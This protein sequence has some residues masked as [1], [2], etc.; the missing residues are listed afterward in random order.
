MV[1]PTL[2]DTPFNKALQSMHKYSPDQA[3]DESGKWTDS[4]AVRAV[5]G[6]LAGGAALAGLAAAGHPLGRAVL[7]GVRRAV[8]ARR[9]R[10]AQQ[11]VRAGVGNFGWLA[12]MR[13][14]VAALGATG[15]ERAATNALRG[16]RNTMSPAAVRRQA[17]F[18][19]A[20]AKKP[21]SSW[22]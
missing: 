4:G 7:P 9:T 14:G 2:F 16:A 20:A 10:G 6:A 22:F 1:E 19:A 17:A 11:A 3:R 18:R 13:A 15:R 8:I 5:G 12:Q 21:K